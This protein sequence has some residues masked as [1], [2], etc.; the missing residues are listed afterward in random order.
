MTNRHKDIRHYILKNALGYPLS[1]LRVQFSKEYSQIQYE[2]RFILANGYVK[3]SFKE[4]QKFNDELE[5]S[6]SKG[7]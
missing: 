3:V 7:V 4:Y 5:K 6:S 2:E 1:S